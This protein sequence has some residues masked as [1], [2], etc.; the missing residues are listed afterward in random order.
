MNH[1][2]TLV[3]RGAVSPLKYSDHYQQQQSA[4]S[5]FAGV[6]GN[7]QAMA[8]L[9]TAQLLYLESSALSHILINHN[10]PRD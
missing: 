5:D 10:H 4:R 1:C 7:E 9:V 3:D 2:L 8:S 6:P